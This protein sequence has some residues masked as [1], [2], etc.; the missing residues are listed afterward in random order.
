MNKRIIKHKKLTEAPDKPDI[1]IKNYNP[2]PF[3]GDDKIVKVNDVVNVYVRY[4]RPDLDAFNKF[5]TTNFPEAV[6]NHEITDAIVSDAGGI[7]FQSNNKDLLSDI[8]RKYVTS[9]KIT[10]RFEKGYGRSYELVIPK[11]DVKK[12]YADVVIDYKHPDYQSTDRDFTKLSFSDKDSFVDA[13]MQRSKPVLQSFSTDVVYDK[14][15]I[16]QIILKSGLS[17]DGFDLKIID[18]TTGETVIDQDM[19]YGYDI[20]YDK[21]WATGQK[22]YVTNL[23]NNLKKKYSVKKVE[24]LPGRYIFSGK[25]MGDE[26]VQKF[27]DK[28]MIESLKESFNESS[29]YNYNDLLADMFGNTSD[30]EIDRQMAL[31][32]RYAKRLGLKR[33]DDMI[34][35]RLE[36]D[37]E[38]TYDPANYYRGT[39]LNDNVVLYDD[40]D[41][42]L[43][44][45]VREL[46]NGNVWLYFANSG[47]AETYTTEIDRINY[48]D[49]ME[50]DSVE[51]FAE[52]EF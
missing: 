37:D 46:I 10:G 35:I 44:S 6:K 33:P 38:Y 48:V 45:L 12:F 40:F 9:G 2:D 11:E 13:V 26:E 42:E 21:R 25:A 16:M 34:I 20:S 36:G 41:T 15:T 22:P 7:E 3:K 18:A 39:H 32:K 27:K 14:P 47:D 24:V 43:V 5:L 52:E 29:E 1:D 49:D 31:M 51:D 30:A 23:I 50:A 19:R 17:S 8:S 4:I 28:Y